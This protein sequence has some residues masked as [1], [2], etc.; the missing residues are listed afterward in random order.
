[1]LGKFINYLEKKGEKLEEIG[2]SAL[3]PG[4]AV[5]AIK[6]V[7]QLRDVGLSTPIRFG[8]ATDNDKIICQWC[9]R[10]FHSRRIAAHTPHFVVIEMSQAEFRRGGLTLYACPE[11]V[12]EK[13]SD[14]DSPEMEKERR[15][16]VLERARRRVGEYMR[17]LRSFPG[18][19]FACECITGKEVMEKLAQDGAIGIQPTSHFYAVKHFLGNKCGWLCERVKLFGWLINLLGRIP[20]RMVHHGIRIEGVRVI[21][22]SSER[23]PGRSTRIKTDSIDKKRTF[24]SKIG[25]KRKERRLKAKLQKETP[26]E[27][28]GRLICRNRAVWIFCNDHQWGEY[29]LLKN[30]CEHFARYC[31]LGE[32]RSTQV[33]EWLESDEQDLDNEIREKLA[34]FNAAKTWQNEP[35]QL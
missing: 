21:H 23:M 8:I 30:N 25:S 5:V 14:T 1:M 35:L 7:K 32:L 27:R 34:R 31:R 26:E 18:D 28:Y 13:R 33:P 29:V 2:S 19:D 3:M 16:A 15:E 10:K 9:I 6:D 22:F 20:W 17:E 11:S 12:F 4:S 24:R